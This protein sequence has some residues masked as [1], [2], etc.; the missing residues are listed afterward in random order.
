MI[1]YAPIG[2]PG[3]AGRAEEHKNLDLFKEKVIVDLSQ[4]YGKTPAQIILNW[5][6]QANHAV[7]PKTTTIGRL[8]ENLQVYDF[9]ITE[10]EYKQICALD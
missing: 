8:K 1:A 7:I 10:D 2:A 6:L 3:T 9:K 4:K 5:H